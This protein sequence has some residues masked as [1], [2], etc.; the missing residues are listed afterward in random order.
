MKRSGAISFR[1]PATIPVSGGRMPEG[2][3]TAMS[4]IGTWLEL[5]AIPQVV[6]LG[7][8]L[9]IT[10]TVI[11]LLSFY[12]PAG[13]WIGSFKGVVAPFFTA[14][15]V[16]FALLAAFIASD[17]WRRNMEASQVVRAEAD[18]LLGLYH[19]TPETAPGAAAV[20]DR[21][22]AYIDSVIRQEWPRMYVGEGAP[23]TEAALD[24]LFR[25]ILSPS[26]QG[27]MQ[28]AADYA[29]VESALKLRTLHATRLSLAADRTDELKWATVLLLAV[30]AQ[31]AIAVVHLERPRPQVAAL[32][33]FSA[34]VVVALGLVAIQERPFVPPLEV[35]PTALEQVLRLT[36]A[37]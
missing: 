28:A 5:P 25:E 35:P 10:G 13:R 23:E 6:L 3:T 37:K 1:L 7:A 27:S 14:V 26:A 32:T 4:I 19:L 29:R 18:V 20:H 21:I 2:G 33:I 8:F 34:S 9:L 17:V 31:L 16:I 30:L 36:P 24:A 22:R 12:G 11:N 15:T